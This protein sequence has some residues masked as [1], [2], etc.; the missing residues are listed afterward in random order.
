MT[1]NKNKLKSEVA[2][3][4]RSTTTTE[5]IVSSLLWVVAKLSWVG[6]IS[7]DKVHNAILVARVGAIL[8][9][10]FKGS[11]PN[12]PLSWPNKPLSCLMLFGKVIDTGC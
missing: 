8:T 6:L 5:I 9:F 3:E 12:K 11:W 4:S 10:P 2:V 7:I 1:A